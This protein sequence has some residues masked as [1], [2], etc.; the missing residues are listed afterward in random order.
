[1]GVRTIITRDSADIS[2]INLSWF[3]DCYNL[4]E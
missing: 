4:Y 1:M 3:N 2:W